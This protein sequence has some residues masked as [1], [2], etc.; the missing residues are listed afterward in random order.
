[1]ATLLQPPPARRPRAG[2]A[3]VAERTVGLD[4]FV[5]S[6]WAPAALGAVLRGMAAGTVFELQSISSRGVQL[7]PAAGEVPGL[8]GHADDHYR[9][10]FLFRYRALD[11][12]LS[13]RDVFQLVERV[14]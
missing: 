14:G 3:P 13:D 4:L 10:R 11:G 2:A 7:F 6:D 12:S 8:V 5:E 1:M 9:C